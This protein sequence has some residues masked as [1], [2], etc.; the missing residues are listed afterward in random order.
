MPMNDDEHQPVEPP[1]HDPPVDSE[2][3]ESSQ[4]LTDNDPL[5]AD[6]GATLRAALTPQRDVRDKAR[7]K[8]DRALHA[9]STA[10]G[11]TSM[12]SCAFDTLRHLLTNPART[13]DR[14]SMTESR[15]IMGTQDGI[16][17]TPDQE[18]DR[19]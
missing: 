15:L 9:R 13:A 1:G 10:S 8:V 12:G 11:L 18:A 3:A 7:H 16:A 17:D 19:D 6:L 4:N 2:G 5:I 14:Y